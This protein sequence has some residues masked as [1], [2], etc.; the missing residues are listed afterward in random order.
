MLPFGT[1]PVFVT[2]TYSYLQQFGVLSLEEQIV[3]INMLKSLTL[4]ESFPSNH[5]KEC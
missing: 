4:T 3:Q 1:A 2:G 5:F